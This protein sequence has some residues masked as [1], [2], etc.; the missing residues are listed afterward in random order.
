MCNAYN[1]R[2]RNEAIL[3]IA[4]AMQ[5]PLLDLPDFPPRHRGRAPWLAAGRPGTVPAR[6][7]RHR[8]P[9]PTLGRQGLRVLVVVWLLALGDGWAQA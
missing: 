4:R 8:L 7:R 9:R 5:L 3:D 6:S 2:H 1:L